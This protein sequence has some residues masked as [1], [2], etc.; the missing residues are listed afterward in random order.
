MDFDDLLGHLQDKHLLEEARKKGPFKLPD[1]DADPDTVT[2]EEV[3]ALLSCPLFTGIGDY[4]S[5]IADDNWIRVQSDLIGQF[6]PELVFQA[7]LDTLRFTLQGEEMSTQEVE[8]VVRH[9][10]EHKEETNQEL[11]HQLRE[12]SVPQIND[13]YQ[14]FRLALMTFAEEYCQDLILSFQALPE[15][16]KQSPDKGYESNVKSAFTEG[17]LLGIIFGRNSKEKVFIDNSEE[18]KDGR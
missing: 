10:H 17:F 13:I 3:F 18:S 15:Y 11:L 2:A 5:I 12:M 7:Q 6:G 16:L 9:D 8:L 4:P 14:H 1:F